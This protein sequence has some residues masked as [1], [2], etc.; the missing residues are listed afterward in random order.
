MK[1]HIFAITVLLL[2]PGIAAATPQTAPD[3]SRI[4]DK[5]D[6]NKDGL[7]TRDEFLQKR[8]EL[9]HRIDRNNDGIIDDLDAPKRERMRRLFDQRVRDNAAAFD[10]NGDGVITTDEF[11]NGPT[12][13]F[14]SIDANIDGAVSQ[15]EL[16][17]ARDAFEAMK[18]AQ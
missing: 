15:T 17:A 6:L 1:S 13:L 7:V 2:A 16:G 9:V 10:L 4:F 11:V 14:D 8:T 12:V 3:P 18:A 5:A